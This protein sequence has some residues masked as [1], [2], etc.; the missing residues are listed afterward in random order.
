MNKT[1]LTITITYYS[2]TLR[3]VHYYRDDGVHGPVSTW[4]ELSIDEANRL[5]WELVKLGGKNKYWANWHNNAISTR[6]VE[7]YGY[8]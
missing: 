2:R 5:M 4:N 6:R 7:F 3:D 1:Y 8:L